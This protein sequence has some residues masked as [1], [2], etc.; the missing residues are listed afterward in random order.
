MY[1]DHR[2]NQ[3]NTQTAQSSAVNPFQINADQDNL[4]NL[5]GSI[6]FFRQTYEPNCEKMPYPAML[7]SPSRLRIQTRITFKI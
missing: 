7:K 6:S 3:T 1:A 5:M 4:V 2:I